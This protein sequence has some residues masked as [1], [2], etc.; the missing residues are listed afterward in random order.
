MNRSLRSVHNYIK[1][2][3]SQN[4]KCEVI[5]VTNTKGTEHEN[6]MCYWHVLLGCSSV[7]SRASL[8]RADGWTRASTLSTVSTTPPYTHTQLTVEG[9]HLQ[10]K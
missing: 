9:K 10:M 8:L 2:G 3:K 1:K 5:T 4:T 7:L 6:E